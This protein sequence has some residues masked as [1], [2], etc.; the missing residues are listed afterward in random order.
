MHIL[1]PRNP[2][3]TSPRQGT[4]SPVP[5]YIAATGPD[6]TLK[7]LSRL[8][9]HRRVEP[10]ALEVRS[11]MLYKKKELNLAPKLLFNWLSDRY[12]SIMVESFLTV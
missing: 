11:P 4:A 3:V 10:A 5:I 1:E 8:V 2:S 6:P 12:S 7:T 9:V